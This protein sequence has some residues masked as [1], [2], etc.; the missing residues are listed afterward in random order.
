M[1]TNNEFKGYNIRS[2]N[3]DGYIV[4]QDLMEAAGYSHYPFGM[5]VMDEDNAQFLSEL[6][7]STGIP[8]MGFEKGL[9]EESQGLT[10]IHRQLAIRVAQWLEEPDMETLI[11]G[12]EE[13]TNQEP[14]PMANDILESLRRSFEIS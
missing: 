13:P 9:V 11:E 12:I 1:F 7:I 4:A 5:F 2:R 6:E 14:A 10:L 8:A 3:N